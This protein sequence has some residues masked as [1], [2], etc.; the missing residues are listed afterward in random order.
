MPLIKGQ[1]RELPSGDTAPASLLPRS[2]WRPRRP[3]PRAPLSE[4]IREPTS[5][6]SQHPF[7]CSVYVSTRVCQS[8]RQDGFRITSR[9]ICTL[10]D[11]MEWRRAL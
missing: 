9:P 8:A 3:P 7:C 2:V 6:R 4:D 1:Q 5:R 10:L 11:W